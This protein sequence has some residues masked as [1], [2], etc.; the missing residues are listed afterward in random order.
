MFAN[1]DTFLPRP[2]GCASA[3]LSLSPSQSGASRLRRTL[4]RMA[5]YHG[6][7]AG[8]LRLGSRRA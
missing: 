3:W 2:T 6:A 7:R 8:T 5:C 4:I 1:Y